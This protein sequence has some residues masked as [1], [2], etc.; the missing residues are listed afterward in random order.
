LGALTPVSFRKGRAS[1]PRLSPKREPGRGKFWT[2]AE[3]AVLREHYAEHGQDGCA[4]RLPGRSRASIYTHARALGLTYRGLKWE[5]GPKPDVDDETIR[6]GWAEL[7]GRGAVSAFA[8]RLGVKRVWLSRRALGLGLTL[9]HKREPKWSGAE[10]ALLARAPLHDLKRASRFFAE[11]GF[12]RSPAAIGV[13]ATRESIS[14]RDSRD[15]FSATQ[16]GALLG[17]ENKTV[18]SWIL[19]GELAAD[20]RADRRLPQQGGSSFAIDPDELRRFVLDHLERIDLRKVEK[21]AFVALIAEATR[22]RPTR[23]IAA[24]ISASRA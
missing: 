4:T 12:R 20:R 10:V 11:H 2:E 15:S 23:A 1:L 13:R 24:A 19:A 5:R 7:E 18:T 16:A 8:D 9:P 3:D 22:L 17:V 21:F 14:R 6:A